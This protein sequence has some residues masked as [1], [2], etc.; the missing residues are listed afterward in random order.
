MSSPT[1]LDLTLC[2]GVLHAQSR[3]AADAP[4]ALCVH[5]VSLSMHAFGAGRLRGPVRR[6]LDRLDAVV[7][8]DRNHFGVMTDDRTVNAV[9]GLLAPGVPAHRTE[10]IS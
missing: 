1:E 10:I 4:P 5:G 3:G 7:E 6:G 2:S 9:A 8:L